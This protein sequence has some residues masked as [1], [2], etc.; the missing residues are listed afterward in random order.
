MKTSEVYPSILQWDCPIAN[1]W[2]TLELRTG[3]NFS[4]WKK[5]NPFHEQVTVTC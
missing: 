1:D 3:S 4:F 5:T 2:V